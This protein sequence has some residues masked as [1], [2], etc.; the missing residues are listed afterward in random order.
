MELKQNRLFTL[1]PA[2]YN[3]WLPLLWVLFGILKIDYTPSEIPPLVSTGLQL[4]LE[5][6]KC[7]KEGWNGLKGSFL[8]KN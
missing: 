7:Q 6:L 2:T 3:P 5:M 8:R 1:F 4:A